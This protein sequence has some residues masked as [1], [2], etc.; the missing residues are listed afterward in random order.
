MAEKNLALNLKRSDIDAVFDGRNLKKWEKDIADY[1]YLVKNLHCADSADIR[2]A[3]RRVFNRFYKVRMK[4]EWQTRYLYP[5]FFRCA[6]ENNANF[7]GILDA[8]SKQTNQL[9]ASFASKLAATIDPRLPVIDKNVLS[10]LDQ[11]LPSS[12]IEFEDR[13]AVVVELHKN[14][15]LEFN[16]FLE[17]STGKY[18]VEKFTGAYPKAKISTMKMLDFVLWQSGGKKEE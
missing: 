7:G 2:P 12:H 3:Y 11:K 13:I 5:L 6:E 18:L 17:T 9:Q 16:R 15:Q 1:I 8:L 4:N 14:M 10:Y